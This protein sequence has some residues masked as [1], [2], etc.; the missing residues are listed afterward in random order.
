VSDACNSFPS[1]RIVS[2]LETVLRL[3]IGGRMSCQPEG[4]GAQ[5]IL[6]GRSH[7]FNARTATIRESMMNSVFFDSAV[8]HDERR[9]S[10]PVSAA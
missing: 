8:N 2:R 1:R 10:S 5:L 3:I 6:I 4:G 9:A 7:A